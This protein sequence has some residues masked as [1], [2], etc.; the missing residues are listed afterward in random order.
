MP[1]DKFASE[2]TVGGR[3]VW[4]IS[5]GG[6]DIGLNPNAYQTANLFK[7]LMDAG[8]VENGYK[9]LKTRLVEHL[10]NGTA[11]YIKKL[12]EQ[13]VTAEPNTPGPERG[14]PRLIV[15]TGLYK[16][17]PLFDAA[18]NPLNPDGWGFLL[19]QDLIQAAS[20]KGRFERQ[21]KFWGKKYSLT[22][23]RA[24]KAMDRLAFMVE[25]M[26]EDGIKAVKD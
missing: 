3:D 26:Y 7:E 2:H 17:G 11:K 15:V 21:F 24:K 23:D 5:V 22:P 20:W 12:L 19:F 9:R 14:L 16:F 4:V 6:N 25:K 18:G 13:I 10:R 1:Q 8:R